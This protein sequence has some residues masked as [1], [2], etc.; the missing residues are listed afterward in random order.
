MNKRKFKKIKSLYQFDI[1]IKGIIF[2]AMF[3][4][5]FF[6]SFTSKSSPCEDSLLSSEEATKQKQKISM[7]DVVSIPPVN[8]NDINLIRN[9]LKTKKI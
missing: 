6:Q 5:L 8:P 3:L 4:S 1:F 7:E 2:K 9:G